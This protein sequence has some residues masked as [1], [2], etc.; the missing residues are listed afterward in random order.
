MYDLSGVRV[1]LYFAEDLEKISRMVEE[2]FTVHKDYSVP[3]DAL[4]DP[5]AYGYRSI[6]YAVSL[7]PHRATLR[8]GV[9]TE[10]EGGDQI[11]RFPK[12]TGR[13]SRKTSYDEVVQ[14]KSLLKRK[15]LRMLPSR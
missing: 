6:H 4:Q 7:A 10:S 2:E 11:G 12:C 1:V 8:S 13:P 9:V 14:S 5:D 15:L 3:Y